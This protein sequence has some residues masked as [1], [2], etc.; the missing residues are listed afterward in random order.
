MK[1]IRTADIAALKIRK[2]MNRYEVETEL[3]TAKEFWYIVNGRFNFLESF[4]TKIPTEQLEKIEKLRKKG[5]AAWERIEELGRAFL[6]TQDDK[7]K[8]ESKEEWDACFA[9]LIHA[10][11]ELIQ[12]AKKLQDL[13]SK[14]VVHTPK[15]TIYGGGGYDDE[16]SI[17]GFTNRDQINDRR[18]AKPKIGNINGRSAR[19]NLGNESYEILAAIRNRSKL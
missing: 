8:G 11:D 17:P 9:R 16:A 15:K 7:F 3:K 6:L 4:G 14:Q 1:R 19:N 2:S 18:R 5:V 12:F 10:K 13:R